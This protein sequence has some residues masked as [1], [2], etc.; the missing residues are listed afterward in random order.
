[1]GFFNLPKNLISTS[2][3]ENHPQRSKIIEFGVPRVNRLF[4]KILKGKILNF[5]H[6]VEKMISIISVQV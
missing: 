4:S 5:P 1:M 3:P 2:Y 6:E